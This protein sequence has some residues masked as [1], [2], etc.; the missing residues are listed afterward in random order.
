MERSTPKRAWVEKTE[1]AARLK[2]RRKKRGVMAVKKPIVDRV[3][4]PPKFRLADLGGDHEQKKVA[5]S[6][7]QG[8]NT[9]LGK[10]RRTSMGG[11]TI[12]EKISPAVPQNSSGPFEWRWGVTCRQQQTRLR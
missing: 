2:S 1:S 8:K 9:P 7:K 5:G 12:V 3:K 4:N 10:N 11:S 6:E